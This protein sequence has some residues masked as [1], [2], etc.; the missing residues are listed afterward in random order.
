[1]QETF[2]LIVN[3]LKEGNNS[4]IAVQ[5]LLINNIGGHDFSTQK[6]CYLLL[7]LPML[8]ASSLDG[9]YL[10]HNTQDEH[11]STVPSL[12]DHYIHR[13]TTPTFDDI[14]LLTFARTYIM[15]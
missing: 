5:K 2:Q 13:Q 15:P 14:I 8:K 6:T 12:L 9:S 10:V 11:I 7:Q 1:M 3:H 4:A